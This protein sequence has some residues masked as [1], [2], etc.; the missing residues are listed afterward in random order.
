MIP[1]VDSCWSK[2]NSP[3]NTSLH[4]TTTSL[5]MPQATREHGIISDRAFDESART[6][7]R[8]DTHI[9]KTRAA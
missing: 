7:I 8:Q 6:D 1:R 4:Y 2:S 9:S 5:A 3:F